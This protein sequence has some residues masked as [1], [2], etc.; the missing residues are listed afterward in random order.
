MWGASLSCQGLCVCVCARARVRVRGHTINTCNTYAMS[1]LMSSISFSISYTH[2]LQH[3]L[4]AR[5]HAHAQRET[6]RSTRI[7][8]WHTHVYARTGLSKSG[9]KV[10]SSDFTSQKLFASAPISVIFCFLPYLLFPYHYLNNSVVTYKYLESSYN[11]SN[12]HKFFWPVSLLFFLPWY[13]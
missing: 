4:H 11:F 2:I 6:R 10:G 9:R 3:I 12:S 7:R 5:M 1:A 13:R 8:T